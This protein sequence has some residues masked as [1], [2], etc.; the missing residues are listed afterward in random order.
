MNDVQEELIA[1]AKEQDLSRIP[2]RRIAEII[3]RPNMSPGVLQYH[4]SQLEKRRLLFIDRKAKTQKLGYGLEDENVYRVPVI[5]VAS[6]GPALMFAD[7]QVEGYVYISRS[8]L[9]A[10]PDTLIALR[11][12][13]DSMNAAK[14]VN[15][16]G[17][18]TA[19]NHGD[20]VIVDTHQKE[21]ASNVG[22]YVV[23][24][25]GGMANIK[26]LVKQRTGIALIS[27]SLSPELYPPIIIAPDDDYMINGRVV[28]VCE[29]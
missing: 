20:Y 28:M 4:F 10:R 12:D 3:K 22:R 21:L 2:L 8:L 26:R 15:P 19:I 16:G 14:V 18:E 5:G 29:G 1:L 6:C 11:A 25:I 7:A 13:G 24:V 9:R 23:S 17:V 27:E